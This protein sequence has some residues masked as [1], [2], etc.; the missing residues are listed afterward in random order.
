[1]R[2]ANAVSVHRGEARPCGIV[3]SMNLAIIMVIPTSSFKKVKGHMLILNVIGMT[4][5][6]ELL[7][8]EIVSVCQAMSFGG[9]FNLVIIFKI[10]DLTIQAYHIRHLFYYVKCYS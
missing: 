7:T 10:I 4:L 6:G 1:M 9:P 8:F 5:Q 3:F 2:E